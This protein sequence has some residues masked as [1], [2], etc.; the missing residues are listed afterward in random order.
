M[1]DQQT[2]TGAKMGAETEAQLALALKALSVM[3]HDVRNL[4][5][6]VTILAGRMEESGDERLAKAAPLLVASMERTV[7]LGVRA[8]QLAEAKASAAEAVPVSRALSLIDG[9]VEADGADV[10][11]LADEAQL[12]T[13]LDELVRNAR[14]AGAARLSAARD[15]GRVLIR[16]SDD[17]GGVPDYAR[18]D[19]FTPFKGAKRRDGTGLG[20]PLAARLARLNGG[21]L[22]LEH[23]GEDGS[24]FLLDLPAA[25]PA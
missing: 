21:T 13:M 4:L 3:R 23:T 24:V 7:A 1:T 25:P 19:L 18:G 6:S 22:S 9:E 20:L 15:G 5:A 16:V 10:A 12:K 14:Q 17:G 11:V 2:E 8:G